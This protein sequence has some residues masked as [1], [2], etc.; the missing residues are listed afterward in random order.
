MDKLKFLKEFEDTELYKLLSTE[1]LKLYILLI[2][3]AD[4]IGIKCRIDQRL[5]RRV[6]GRIDL[7]TLKRIKSNIERYGLA[8]IIIP[9]DER[10]IYFILHEIK[11]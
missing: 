2:M 4:G 1:E 7:D 8:D 11:G 10:G 5:L 3:C 9:E 6:M